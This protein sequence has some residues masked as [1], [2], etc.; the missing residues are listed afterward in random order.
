MTDHT[1]DTASDPRA[2]WR[3]LPPEPTEWVEEVQAKNPV[4]DPEKPSDGPGIGY[5]G[6][7]LQP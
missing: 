2:R 4:P 1:D 6:G 3:K 7:L 5:A